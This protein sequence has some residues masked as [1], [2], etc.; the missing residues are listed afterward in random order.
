MGIVSALEWLVEEFTGRSGTP[1]SL[2]VDGQMALDDK[3][4]TE[5]FR[6]VQESLTNISRH[7]LASAVHIVLDRFDD[8]YLLE[9]RDN[10]RGFDPAKRKLKSFG[11]I[12]L[13]E[14]ALVLGGE[15]RVTSAPGQGT[16]V[17]V[18]FPISIAM[19]PR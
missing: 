13:R 14:R 7:A 2:R 3:R 8:H 12:G 19:D 1:C 11:L 18:S 4:A 17:K 5:V 16:V 6:I 15:A 9:V 10:G